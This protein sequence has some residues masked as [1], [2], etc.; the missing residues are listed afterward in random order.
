MTTSLI[1]KVSF[2]DRSCNKVNLTA[3]N[4]M[5][6]GIHII[7]SIHAADM[8]RPWSILCGTDPLFNYKVPFQLYKYGTLHVSTAFCTIKYAMSHACSA[9]SKVVMHCSYLPMFATDSTVS[10]L[11]M[12]C[13]KVKLFFFQKKRLSCLE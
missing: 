1:V 9:F 7:Q 3:A 11:R 10:I 8:H 12:T 2:T 5:V 6:L 13:F 4:G